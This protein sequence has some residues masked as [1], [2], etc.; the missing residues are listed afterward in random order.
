MQRLRMHTAPF[1]GFCLPERSIWAPAMCLANAVL[2]CTHAGRG[3]H[4]CFHSFATVDSGEIDYPCCAQASSLVLHQAVSADMTEAHLVFASKAIAERVFSSVIADGEG[5]IEKFLPYLAKFQLAGRLQG[6]IYE[7]W[8]L[9]RVRQ[10]GKLKMAKRR[11]KRE[12]PY[13]MI[14]IGC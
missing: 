3:S 6:A 7:Q 10:G 11:H 14:G 4:T 13:Q 12:C 2:L 8:A 5:A 9:R 1:T